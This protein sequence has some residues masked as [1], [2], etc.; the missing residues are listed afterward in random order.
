MGVEQAAKPGRMSAE[1]RR[2]QLLDVTKSI[3]ERRGF[4]AV[5]IEAVARE[6]GVSRPIVYGH[7]KDLPGLLEALVEREGARALAQLATV[8][9]SDL[10][11]GDPRDSLLGALRGY[12]SAAQAD[13]VTWRLV[14]MPPEGAPGVLRE[15]IA[16]GRGAVLAQLLRR[17]GGPAGAHRPRAL[18]ARADPEPHRLDPGRARVALGPGTTSGRGARADDPDVEQVCSRRAGVACSHVP[19]GAIR[20]RLR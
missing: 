6:A 17:R 11:R 1:E 19:R 14:L 2:G 15:Q 12:L 5:S 4:H 7:F 16:R 3:V 9:P 8:L 20:R 10:R 18:P 13:P